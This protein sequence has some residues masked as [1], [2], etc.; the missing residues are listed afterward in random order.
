[1]LLTVFI[2]CNL[3]AQQVERNDCGEN[4]RKN[5]RAAVDLG[6]R[7]QRIAQLGIA[8][9]LPYTMKI[10]VVVFYKDAPTVTDADINRNIT[11]MVNFYRPHNICFVLSDIE[12]VKDASMANFNAC[13]LY[14]SRCV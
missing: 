1:M 5:A 12:Y 3:C 7:Q 9:T 4:V 6:L 8:A 10:Q 13:L 14:T 11:N 2:C